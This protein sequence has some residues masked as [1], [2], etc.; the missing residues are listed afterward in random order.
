MN[1]IM[2]NDLSTADYLD[3]LESK[4]IFIIREAFASMRN[5]ALLWSI[6]K[7][8]T[9]MLW[10]ARK[11]FFGHIPFPVMHID[12]AFKFKEI[13]EFRDTF[14]R[15]WG[16]DLLISKNKEALKRSVSPGKG[17]F[18]CCTALKTDA[19]KKTIEQYH[20]NALLLAIRRDEHGIR[21]KERC[22]SVRGADFGWNYKDQ[23][24]ELWDLYRSR[25]ADGEHIRVH[26]MLHW[27]ELDIWK[28]IQREKIPIVDL[29]KARGGKRYRS[30]GCHTCCAPV[31]SKADTLRKI[32]AELETTR[33]AER[34][35]RAQDKEDT[36]TMQ[37]LRSLGYM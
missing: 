24:T 32:I 23:P 34:S 37:K 11:A 35:G 18:D 27:T 25:V 5:I 8:S 20:F 33:I 16:L 7:D 6:G 10:I 14:S 2:R 29:Y 36:Y 12:T 19:L 30:I 13:Y 17:K 26:P 22:F 21:A 9:T 1:L 28:Y 31:D 15:K 4:S 3:D